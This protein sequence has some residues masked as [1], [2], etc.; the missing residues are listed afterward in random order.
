VT[1]RNAI[2]ETRGRGHQHAIAS[3]RQVLDVSFRFKRDEIVTEGVS[4][5]ARAQARKASNALAQTRNPRERLH[6]VRTS[7]K[8]LRALLRLVRP[9]VGRARFH[10]EDARLRKMSKELSELRDATV[11]IESC[12][13]LA[14]LVEKPLQPALPRV[15]RLLES[16]RSELEGRMDGPQ[17]RLATA[18]ELR[19]TERRVERWISARSPVRGRTFGALLPG[20]CRVYRRGRRA[21]EA[22]Y[23]PGGAAAALHAWRRA[24]KYHGWHLRL[25]GDMLPAELHG[26]RDK[27]ERLARL[28]GEDHDL[29]LL[30]TWLRLDAVRLGD[31]VKLRLLLRRIAHHQVSLRARARGLGQALYFA[32][33]SVFS[34]R[35]QGR[36]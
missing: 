14:G 27:I 30:A 16:R 15:R 6:E 22:A 29:T 35:L 7:I 25:L 19:E 32:R 23:D 33:T 36:P 34:R 31:N 8:K 18:A 2:W 11:L 9:M 3:K 10:R 20:L 5:I 26:R 4:R 12:K 28:L 21:F 1:T 24:V 17:R 13:A